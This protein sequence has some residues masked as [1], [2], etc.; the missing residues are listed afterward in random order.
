MKKETAPQPDAEGLWLTG[1]PG[2]YLKAC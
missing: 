1:S 2:W